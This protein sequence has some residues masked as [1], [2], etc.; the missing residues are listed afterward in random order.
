MADSATTPAVK[1][2][3]EM[4]ADVNVE[5]NEASSRQQINSGESVKTLFGKL[6]KF[7]TD[8]KAVAFSGAYSDLS[9]APDLT[10]YALKSKYGDTTINVGR[11]AGTDVGARSTAEGYGNTANGNY[12]HA[13]GEFTTASGGYSHA[14]G[15]HTTAS[16][17]MS[18]AEGNETTASGA[19]SHAEGS[20]TTASGNCSH[21]G[22][23]GTKALHDNEVAY[24][25]YNESKDDTV[26][27]VGDG[28][29]DSARH[30]AFEITKTGGKLH[31]KDIAV[32]DDIPSELPANGGNADTVDGKHA[33]DFIPISGGTLTG[34]IITPT[35][36]SM[37]IIPATNNY[38]QIGSSDKKFFRMY[39]TTF[40]GTLSGNSSSATK[41][42]TSSGSA[43]QPVYFSGGKPVACT[44]TLSKSVPSDAVFTDT[45]PTSL[46][47]NGG[48]A[49]TARQVVSP[50]SKARLWED[51]EG[52]NLELV[53]PDG[54]HMMQMDIYNN[55]D[56]RMYFY[57]GSQLIFPAN[58]SFSTGKF[59]INGNADTVDGMH[60]SD[61]CYANS[62]RITGAIRVN[63]NTE[64]N[65]SEG[66]RI[67]NATNG[68][69]DIVLGAV[70]DYGITSTGIYIGKTASNEF[71]ISRG[72]SGDSSN[73]SL[74][75]D[76]N[77]NWN[78]NGSNQLIH[79]GNIGSQSVNYANGA[80]NAD[81]VDGLHAWNMATL[82]AEGNSH[83]A[84]F[85]M[86]CRYNVLGD[87]KF[88][89]GVSGGYER[90]VAVGYAERAGSVPVSAI[91]KS[92]TFTVTTNSS[93]WNT[94]GI[95]YPA[96][97]IIGYQC[98]TSDYRVE[99]Y[100]G[101]SA[102]EWY[103]YAIQQY[104]NPGVVATNKAVSVTIF[105]I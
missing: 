45:V 73:G 100:K 60:A 9:G 95:T 92:A 27:S 58:Y 48:T 2:I 13:E 67:A 57:D 63:P 29:S 83:G 41:L 15:I 59:D 104:P 87:G 75:L 62:P 47:A 56:F 90:S 49:D 46:P 35:D 6:R 101:N 18:H 50:S 66:I 91:I 52:G 82:S 21:T 68:Y 105:Y 3:V 44:Y 103:V 12:S 85:P 94:L 32:I 37:G 78:V 42:T 102:T 28:T 76:T 81:T 99:L 20:F 55:A 71:V 65:F 69:S 40:Y 16:G 70:D 8:L 26:F 14:E 30:N 61:F 19:N 54:V 34:S 38:G 5:F 11:K 64:G 31:D 4:E 53:A 43:T 96:Y 22:G 84:S 74:R 7:L 93:G 51:N 88:Y 86:Y 97:N 80:G 77:G 79:S 39:A 25:K 1:N 10:Q 89:I 72:G 33:S 36:D 17:E 23:T 24:G 98:N